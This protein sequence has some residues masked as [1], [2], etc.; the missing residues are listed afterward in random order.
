MRP[1]LS[2]SSSTA[3]RPARLTDREH[4][5]GS[6]ATVGV[7]GWNASLTHLGT[8]A[9][10]ASRHIPERGPELTP[11]PGTGVGHLLGLEWEGPAPTSSDRPGGRGKP[12]AHSVASSSSPLPLP[13]G[14][15]A[16][17]RCEVGPIPGWPVLLGP[18]HQEPQRPPAFQAARSPG[19]PSDFA[20]CRRSL[21]QIQGCSSLQ[22]LEQL[23]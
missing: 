2:S 15:P 12:C 17:C 9:K 16:G 5:R 6:P 11:Q 22:H 19:G 3:W 20:A 13:F 14:L 23:Q 1:R 8:Y 4:G 10:T 21:E 18:A 7:A